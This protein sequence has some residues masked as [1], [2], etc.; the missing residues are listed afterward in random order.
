MSESVM[1]AVEKLIQQSV[2]VVEASLEVPSPHTRALTRTLAL[3]WAAH[4]ELAECRRA[5]GSA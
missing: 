4:D 2:N 3:L 1:K 5:E